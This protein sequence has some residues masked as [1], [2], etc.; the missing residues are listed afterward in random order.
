MQLLKSISDTLFTRPPEPSSPTLDPTDD[1][2]PSS[3]AASER[4]VRHALGLS[5]VPSDS[6]LTP[7]DNEPA[8]Q[9]S[10]YNYANGSGSARSPPSV[11]RLLRQST[12]HLRIE[13]P[14]PPRGRDPMLKNKSSTAI[15]WEERRLLGESSKKPDPNAVRIIP[16]Q[17]ASNKKVGTCC[18]MHNVSLLTFPHDGISRG[19]RD[20]GPVRARGR[21]RPLY[22]SQVRP[23]IVVDSPERSSKRRRVQSPEGKPKQI[24]ISDDDQPG[25]I[26]PVATRSITAPSPTPSQLS[27]QMKRPGLI[28][29]AQ[30]SVYRSVDKS[31]RVPRTS[32]KK[33]NSFTNHLSSPEFDV[34]FT[35]EA[36]KERRRESIASSME[37]AQVPRQLPEQTSNIRVEIFGKP[38]VLNGHKPR[39]SISRESPDEL[40]GDVT[41]RP[42]PRSLELRADTIDTSSKQPSDIRPTV[43][44]SNEK[45]RHGGRKI[46]KGQASQMD[47]PAPF[48]LNYFRRGPTFREV[49]DGENNQITV[50]PG[51]GIICVKIA[52]AGYMDSFPLDKVMKVVVGRHPSSKVRF[53][54]RGTT[55]MDNKLDVVLI[56]SRERDRLEGLLKGLG[57]LDVKLQDKDRMDRIFKNSERDHAN[58]A[59]AVN[60]LKRPLVVVDAPK[61]TDQPSSNPPKRMKLSDGLRGTDEDSAQ[62]SV[63]TALAKPGS[64]SLPTTLDNLSNSKQPS[65]PPS[66]PRPSTVVEI[67]VKKFNPSSQSSIRSTRSMA[68]NTLT[69]LVCDDDNDD[70]EDELTTQARHDLDQKWNKKPLVYPRFGKKKAEVN[71]FD[72]E[73]LAPS[74]FLNDNIIGFYMRFLEDHL[75]RCNAEA[76]KRVYWFNS[77]FFATLTNTPRNKRTI[78]YEGVAKWTRNVDIFSYDHIVVPINED[79]HWYLAIICNLPHLE[80]ILDVANPPASRGPSEVREVPETPDPSQGGDDEASGP[81]LREEIARRSLASMSLIEKQEGSKS[82]EEDWPEREELPAISRA[83]FSE[84]SSQP[85]PGSPQESEEGTPKKTRKLKRK[86]SGPKYDFDQPIIISFDSL[87]MP[88]SGTISILKEYLLAEAKS[89]RGIE[90]DKQLIKGMTAKEIPQQ[91][92]FSDCGLYLLAYIEKFVQDPDLFCRRLLRK[93]MRVKEDW[94][95]LRSGLLRTR[96]REFMELLYAEQEQLTQTKADE[97]KL[98]VDQQPISYLLGPPVSDEA[99]DKESDKQKPQEE[100]SPPSKEL[101]KSLRSRDPSLQPGSPKL[102][103]VE[104]QSATAAEPQGPHLEPSESETKNQ[105]PRREFI[106]VPDSQDRGDA[107]ATNARTADSR[108]PQRPPSSKPEPA[109]TVYVDDS[110]DAQQDP[111]QQNGLDKRRF[112]DRNQVEETPPPPEFP[113]AK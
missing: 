84:H 83:K 17:T 112:E 98:M 86:P 113:K 48:L 56:S 12:P 110:D 106:E 72:L 10:P 62:L 43:F 42:V 94:P 2:L 22:G 24:S 93:D 63:D 64:P 45:S 58:Y 40:Q 74:Q 41:V 61:L 78:N 76:A 1:P 59:P 73:R 65:A 57:N 87:N 27:G 25:R 5:S 21:E 49:L 3:N 103:V 107:P 19:S 8:R 28:N 95:P 20:S 50:Y 85:Q 88:R 68:R 44:I 36:A 91:P 7:L 26:S 80:G 92:N 54:L 71:A 6:E 96:L 102:E 47:S 66:D 105:S 109:D 108:S 97:E 14:E 38:P 46:K 33:R 37:P 32:P 55:G 81:Q 4:P 67:P 34:S 70:I 60:D 39:T 99:K 89:K 77:Y 18:Q 11:R 9:S 35:R 31:A 30:S 13:M 100:R 53:E 52:D 51:A 75:Q 111:P 104:V 90:I 79:Q 101:K 23:G 82:G 16:G 69:T 29:G 15:D